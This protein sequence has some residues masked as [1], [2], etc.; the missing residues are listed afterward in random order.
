MSQTPE[1][2]LPAEFAEDW[3]PQD[4]EFFPDMFAGAM[5][6]R[7]KV[8]SGSGANSL[9]EELTVS[10]PNG[11]TVRVTV[12]D[13]TGGLRITQVQ[14]EAGRGLLSAVPMGLGALL[15]DDRA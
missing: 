15:L 4:P 14:D 10:S 11:T 5:Q 12:D 9:P 1:I 2:D 8:S 3:I 7:L 13:I 6:T